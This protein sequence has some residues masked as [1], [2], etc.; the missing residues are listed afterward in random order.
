MLI[1]LEGCDATGITT[2]AN[3]L[4][5]VLNATIIHCTA[6][7]PNDMQFFTNIA[8]AAAHE[9]IIADRLCYSQFVY[10]SEVNRPI[11]KNSEYMLSWDALYHLET[12]L[13]EY[14]TKVIYTYASQ[15]DIADRMIA[16]GENPDCVSGILDGYTELWKKT[17]I[18]PILF[19]T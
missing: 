15:K 5:P 19:R 1:I 11:L 4:A 13:L 16:R 14:D 9:N 12:R 2:L 8:Y 7:T 17:L 10:Q 6:E 18:K 3:L